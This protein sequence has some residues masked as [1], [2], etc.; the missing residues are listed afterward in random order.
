MQ[1]FTEKLALAVSFLALFVSA[2]GPYQQYYLQKSELGIQ[3]ASFGFGQTP[4][5]AECFFEIASYNTGNRPSAIL[6]VTL[7]VSKR[8]EHGNGFSSKSETLQSDSETDDF[9]GIV[10]EPGALAVTRVLFQGC[11]VPWLFAALEDNAMLELHIRTMD[12]HGNR[13]E[14]FLPAGQVFR[15]SESKVDV[16]LHLLGKTD[17]LGNFMYGIE[18]QQ[19]GHLSLTKTGDDE[20]IFNIE[21]QISSKR[22]N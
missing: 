19:S 18:N 17:V 10:I 7:L 2:I 6:D 1:N 4:G 13:Y 9:E 11:Y 16:S 5:E 14:T 15:K 21:E 12:H 20:Y 8:T 22:F 3:L